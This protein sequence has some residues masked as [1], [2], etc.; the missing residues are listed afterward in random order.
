MDNNLKN[1]YLPKYQYDVTVTPNDI[2]AQKHRMI[3]S[4]DEWQR[5]WGD[6]GAGYVNKA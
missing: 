2:L 5:H 4:E 6:V 3:T 1:I